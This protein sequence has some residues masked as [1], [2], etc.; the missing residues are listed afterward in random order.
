LWNSFQIPCFSEFTGET[1][2]NTCHSSSSG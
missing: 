2:L 1:Y